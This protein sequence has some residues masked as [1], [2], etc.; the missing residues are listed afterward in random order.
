MVALAAS[1]RESPSVQVGASPR[2]TLALLKLGRATAMLDGRDFVVPDDIKAVAVPA[3]AHRLALRPERPGLGVGAPIGDERGARPWGLL[4]R[5]VI[6]TA[7]TAVDPRVWRFCSYAQ[8]S[9][10]CRR[11]PIHYEAMPVGHQRDEQQ[12]LER[13]RTDLRAIAANA[14]D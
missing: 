4:L 12:V 14:S 2:G 9:R 3:L 6:G 8:S 10:G 13:L 1:T 5:R 11:S 7:L